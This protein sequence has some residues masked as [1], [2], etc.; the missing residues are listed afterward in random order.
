MMMDDGA[1][2]LRRR[3]L[4]AHFD[5]LFF[6]S[7]QKQNLFEEC[8]SRSILTFR[9]FEFRNSH[10]HNDVQSVMIMS[11][12]FQVHNIHLVFGDSVVL[13]PGAL[14]EHRLHDRI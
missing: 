14:S 12:L 10:C 7:Q 6:L 1:C 9:N 3:G 8:E 11:L 2:S 13:S 4:S 5:S